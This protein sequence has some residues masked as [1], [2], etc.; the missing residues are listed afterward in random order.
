YLCATNRGRADA[1]LADLHRQDAVR[2]LPPHLPAALHPAVGSC[3]L[4]Q[5]DCAVRAA[6]DEPARRARAADAAVR[7]RSGPADARGAARARVCGDVAVADAVR[8]E[9]AVPEPALPRAAPA[10]HA[11]A[12][13]VRDR[14]SRLRGAELGRPTARQPR[15]ELA[16]G[17]RRAGAAAGPPDPA[18]DRRA[19][20]LAAPR[21]DRAAG[22]DHRAAAAPGPPLAPQGRNRRSAGA[23]NGLYWSRDQTGG[24]E[25]V[26]TFRDLLGSSSAACSRPASRGT[27]SIRRTRRTASCRPPKVA[28]TSATT[29]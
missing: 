28:A 15:R 3:R 8:R 19:R 11:R 4:L 7:R 23:R 21:A 26:D 16:R 1:K 9:H 5:P 6:G 20:S 25:W 13:V 29:S 24:G 10:D 18:A 2:S 12:L 22:R 17:H 14:D 27:A